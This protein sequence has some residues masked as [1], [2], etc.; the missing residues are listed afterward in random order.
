MVDKCWNRR[1][2]GRG[3]TELAPEPRAAFDAV[4]GFGWDVICEGCERPF[5]VTY[6]IYETRSMSGWFA[7]AA[8]DA[9]CFAAEEDR[10]LRP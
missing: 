6:G 5:R 8:G 4:E 3:E 9:L 1:R 2:L 10:P 7:P